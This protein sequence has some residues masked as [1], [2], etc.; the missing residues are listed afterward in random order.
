MQMA[1]VIT[2]TESHLKPSQSLHPD[3]LPKESLSIFRCDCSQMSKGGVVTFASDALEPE[4]THVDVPSLE[5][6]VVHLKQKQL[7]IIT[8]YRRPGTVTLKRFLQSCEKLL[9][10]DS[11]ASG[12]I[13]I[14]G[15][16]NE[17]VGGKTSLLFEGKGFKQAKHGPTTDYGSTIDHVYYRGSDKVQ[18]DIVNSYYSD[19][20]LLVVRLHE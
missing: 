6:T 2:F 20:D 1:D 8:I 10:L 4:Q 12:N 14:V 5:L 9:S 17:E 13:L 18:V 19:H 16:F 11:L 7:H 15:D 3:V